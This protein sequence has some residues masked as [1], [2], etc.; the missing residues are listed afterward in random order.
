MTPIVSLN[1]IMPFLPSFIGT[2]VIVFVHLQTPRFRF[3][4]KQDNLWLPA[5]VGIAM[6]YV[7]VDILPVFTM[8]PPDS[9]LR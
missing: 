5:S 2:T 9:D 7:F 3:M 4:R 8:K 1:S 6:A